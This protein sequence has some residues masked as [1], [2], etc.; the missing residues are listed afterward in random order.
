M[1]PQLKNNYRVI[2]Q[3]SGTSLDGLD[4][5]AV[6][7]VFSDGKWH[8]KII[9]AKTI[10][11]PGTWEKKLRSA[12]ELTGSELLQVHNEYGK[13]LAGQ[14]NQFSKDFSA[15]LIASH[16][17]TIFHQP[18]KGFTFQ[19]GNGSVIAA[20]TGITTVADF[21]QPDVSLGGQGAPL[22]PAG[23]RL[24]FGEFD[25]CLNLGGFANISFEKNNKRIAFDICPANIILNHFAAKQRLPFDN[26][27]DLGRNGKINNELLVK[28][29]SLDFYKKEPPKSLGREWIESE[30][31][32][33]ID[34][35]PGSD[36]DKLRTVYEHFA[37]QLA[38]ATN[39]PGK[40]L[41]TGGGAFNKFLIER[42]KELSVANIV[43][44]DSETINFKEALIFAFLG[45]LRIRNEVNCLASVTGAKRDHSTGVI[46][47]P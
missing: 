12:H 43:I 28:L 32:P 38:K 17:H 19:L 46:F 24:L 1:E 22:V 16:G 47:L 7:F 40:M 10:S 11:Y 31:L 18:E 35:F 14:I 3:M 41:V 5:V 25:Y 9:D 45:V 37:I 30:F 27:G 39:K 21:R 29:N 36:S 2:G 23:D 34:G 33:N 4:L 8:Y 42:L 44:P 13:F 20:E 26:N 15:D 6:E